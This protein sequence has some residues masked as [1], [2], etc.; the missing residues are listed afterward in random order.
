ML[1]HHAEH[2]HAKQR[3]LQRQE[4]EKETCHVEPG[5]KE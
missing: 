1:L 5:P 4:S 2:V 3:Q